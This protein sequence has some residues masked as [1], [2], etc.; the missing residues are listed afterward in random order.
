MLP[1]V[2]THI[3]MRGYQRHEMGHLL[4]A[5]GAF[6]VLVNQVKNLVAGQHRLGVVGQER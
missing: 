3:Q 5:R 6:G 1:T 4:A 2:G